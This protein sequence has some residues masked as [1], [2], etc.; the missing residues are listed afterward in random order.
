M[1]V[2]IFKL[3]TGEEVIANEESSG[4][5]HIALG[6]PR[7]LHLVSTEQGQQAGLAP[8]IITAPDASIK[9]RPDAVIGELSCPADVEKAYMQQTS[10]IQLV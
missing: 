8:W 9:I 4:C 3:V 6:K 1:T 5:D 2:K 7:V 10:S